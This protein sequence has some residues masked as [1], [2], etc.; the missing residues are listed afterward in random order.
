M[1]KLRLI[2]WLL[3]IILLAFIFARVFHKSDKQLVVSADGSSNLK[4]VVNA[5]GCERE[6][7]PWY[8]SDNDCLCFFIPG[9]VDDSVVYLEKGVYIET[10]AGKRADQDAIDINKETEVM[11]AAG[12]MRY[13]T[14]F[15][16][17]SKIP[18]LFVETASGSMDTIHGD[19]LNREKGRVLSLS[20]EGQV[21]YNNEFKFI[22]GH[23]NDT[24]MFEK[25]PYS[26]EFDKAV[27]LA[28]VPESKEWVLLAMSLEGDK[29]HSKIAYDMAKIL[30]AESYVEAEWVDLY[31]NGEYRG[32]YLLAQ[33]AKGK[34]EFN[35]KGNAF[36]VEKEIDS[37]CGDT[38]EFLLTKQG[39]NFIAVRPKDKNDYSNVEDIL[40]QREEEIY[41]GD[42]EKIGLDSFVTQYIIDEISMNYD[43]YKTSAYYFK[44]SGSDILYAGPAWDYDGAFG[45]Y[46]HQGEDWVNYNLSVTDIGWGQLTWWKTLENNEVFTNAVA[47]KMKSKQ[48]ELEELFSNRIDEYAVLIADSAYS[49]SIRWK[50]KGDPFKAGTYKEFDSNVR[51]LKYF[52][53][54]RLEVLDSRYEIAGALSF[55]GNGTE[56]TVI[57][58]DDE[59]QVICD[60]KIPDGETLTLGGIPELS[61]C[62][63]GWWAFEYSREG[64]CEYIPIL[65]D[66]SLIFIKDE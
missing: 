30:E 55:K 13:R 31:T 65:E 41:A 6:I 40:N 22:K 64:Y 46:L 26:I 52:L 50:Y 53:S 28:G 21:Q 7:L 29:I 11:L 58:R 59:G 19:K 44:K 62:Q 16:R 5:E 60:M 51:Y 2:I 24:W 57:F 36:L 45:E 42:F 39:N 35:Q 4:M 15:I 37:R 3:N 38:P 10:E 17:G 33:S 25:K 8:D 32:L 9:S 66:S 49:D 47:E 56:H 63:N 23:G 61:G 14:V 20:P 48:Q 27:S 43:A 18:A 54:H 12:D 34:N 1:K